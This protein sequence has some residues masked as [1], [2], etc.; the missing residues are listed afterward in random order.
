ML[1]LKINTLSFVNR[2]KFTDIVVMKLGLRLEAASVGHRTMILTFTG[3]LYFDDKLISIADCTYI[4][5]WEKNVHNSSH[6]IS[7]W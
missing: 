3:D 6:S 7:I 1:P 4:K 2:E 5:E